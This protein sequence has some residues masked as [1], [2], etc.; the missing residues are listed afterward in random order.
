VL[1]EPGRTR[2]GTPQRGLFIT[3]NVSLSSSPDD[4]YHFLKTF[5]LYI[6]DLLKKARRQMYEGSAAQ[7]SKVFGGK[8]AKEKREN[9]TD[10][11]EERKRK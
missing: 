10:C 4:A 11:F 2:S 7:K 9:V 3:S 5:S 8:K 6:I 1:E